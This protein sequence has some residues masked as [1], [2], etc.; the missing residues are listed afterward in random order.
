M[1]SDKKL[2][3]IFKAIKFDAENSTKEVKQD[4]FN[5]FEKSADIFLGEGEHTLEMIEQIRT[6]LQL[7]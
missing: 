1:V 4:F 7:E 3:E 5:R 6:Y 2:K